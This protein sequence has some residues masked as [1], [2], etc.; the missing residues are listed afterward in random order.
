VR[1]LFTADEMRRLDARA[2][3]PGIPGRS[4]W[5]TP[6]RGPRTPSWRL[7]WRRHARIDIACGK[8]GNGGDSFGGAR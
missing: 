6:G 2:V 4:S 3:T 8:G 5:N 1:P 7:G